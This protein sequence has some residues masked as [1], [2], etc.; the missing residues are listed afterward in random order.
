MLEEA[1]KLCILFGLS[2]LSYKGLEKIKFPA[3]RLVGPILIIGCIQVLT[4]FSFAIPSPLK[5]L[6]SVVFGVYLGLR[7]NKKAVGRLRSSLIPALLISAIYLVITVLYGEIIQAV[8]SVDQTSAFLAVIPGGIAEASILAVSYNA[9]LAQVSAFQLIRFLSIVLIVP[10]VT[11]WFLVPRLKLS[12]AAPLQRPL[13]AKDTDLEE[14]LVSDEKADPEKPSET[15]RT[16]WHTHWVWLFAIG[17][18]GSFVFKL[19]HFPAALL[20]GATF[21]VSAYSLLA[22]HEVKTPPPAFYNL[23]QV[24]MGM[25]IGTSFTRASIGTMGELILPMLILTVLILLTSVLLGLLFMKLFK[26]DF[27]TA[28][29]AVLPGGM[30]AMVVLAD[31]FGADVVIISSLQLVRLLTAV[32][33][34][35]I[36]YQVLLP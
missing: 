32:M 19:V 36:I 21:S 14:T 10:L 20:L 26:W 7:F 1:I 4:N 12:K 11:Q 2:F 6:F 5:I 31:E 29:M 16:R 8:S 35:P 13:P 25:V 28:F 17:A 22:K 15:F 23:A 30:S 24:G 27:L 18:L 33:I 3:S 9:N 34:I